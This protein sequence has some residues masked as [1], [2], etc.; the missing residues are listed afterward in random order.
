M[1]GAASLCFFRSPSSGWPSRSSSRTSTCV[2]N[3]IAHERI[4]RRADVV[5]LLYG[6]NDIAVG[7]D[8]GLDSISGSEL[9]IFQRIV[10][11]RIGHRNV[12]VP[13]PHLDR[14]DLVFLGQP[15]GDDLD[16]GGLDRHCLQVDARHP[17]LGGKGGGDVVFGADTLFDDQLTNPLVAALAALQGFSRSLH[18]S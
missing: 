10:A 8:V 14:D 7:R 2:R 9:N 17:E 6:P 13:S 5:V 18:G 3:D 1:I 11:E 16:P 12:Q 15:L 4:D